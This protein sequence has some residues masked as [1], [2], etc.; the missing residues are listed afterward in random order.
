[1]F[2]VKRKTFLI[3]AQRVLRKGTACACRRR[4]AAAFS[5]PSWYGPPTRS[6]MPCPTCQD[7]PKRALLEDMEEYPEK[8]A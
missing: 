7:D 2:K 1:M 3:P 8:P 6:L 5:T 4:G